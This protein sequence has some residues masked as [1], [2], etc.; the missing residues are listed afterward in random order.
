[1]SPRQLARVGEH[2]DP[3]KRAG[4]LVHGRP[5]PASLAR[6]RDWLEIE[7]MDLS[8]CLSPDG[9]EGHDRPIASAGRAG[10]RKAGPRRSSSIGHLGCARGQFPS[11]HLTMTC[12]VSGGGTDLGAKPLSGRWQCAHWS[13]GES[14]CP[15][16]RVQVR[17]ST[18]RGGVGGIPTLERPETNTAPTVRI[19]ASAT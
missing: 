2:S 1:M 4:H 6:T 12:W 7:R 11:F 14:G 5:R 17:R 10:P 8:I 19:T 18:M 9:S 16:A 13:D 15:I 3:G